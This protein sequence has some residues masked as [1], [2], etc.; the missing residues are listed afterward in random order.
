MKLSL[1]ISIPTSNKGVLTPMQKQVNDFKSRV[2]ANGGVFEANACL[3][4]QLTILN[5]IG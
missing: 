2:I 1:G 5:N 4:A 3:V